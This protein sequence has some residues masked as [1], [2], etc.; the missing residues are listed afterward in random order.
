MTKISTEMLRRIKHPA[1]ADGRKVVIVIGGGFAGL[2]AAKNLADHSE[3]QVIL[4]DRKNHHLFQ[5]LLYQ[6]ATAGLNPADIA[7]PIRAQF[8][9]VEN[10]SVHWS[11]IVGVDLDSK[12]VI[13]TSADGDSATEEEKVILEYDYLIVA[14]GA[15][16]SYFGRTDW[17]I[18]APGLKTLEQ[19][20]EMRRR[21]LSAFEK[22][23]NE[24]D[25]VKQT[26]LL[27]FIVIGGGPTGVELAGAI[28]DISR[29]VIERDFKRIDPSTAKI[30]L[31]E[32]GPRILAAFDPALSI[33]AE[34]D[35]TRLGVQVMTSTRVQD[36]TA[37][38]VIANGYS[39]PSK[40]VFW[41]AG[42]EASK[43]NLEPAPE[44]DRTGRIFV[45]ADLSL[46]TH[47]EVFVIGDMAAVKQAS[48]SFVPGLAPAAIQQGRHAA[49]NILS[50]ISGHE[51]KAFRYNDKGIMA[52]IGKKRAVMQF[53]KLKMSGTLAWLAWFFVH[54]IALVGF[55]N[56]V[57][58]ALAWSWNYLFSR[59]IARLI[60]TSRWTND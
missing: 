51:R 17:E 14:C 22:A 29:T 38:G 50:E 28:A 18:H 21:L 46:D 60:T 10:V 45:N 55:R 35:L 32:G 23:E 59:R 41:A 25:P 30:I 57:A 11:K 36:V 16:H 54:I 20:T 43:L 19:A 27:T 3:V 37:D 7:S 49:N 9:D 52:T 15:S 34:E 2:N 33:K 4:A 42:V 6:V 40:C 48:G 56:R 58:V 53:G 13:A 44:R 24:S 26:E 39:I 5:P 12:F 8:T 31:I 47:R 1:S